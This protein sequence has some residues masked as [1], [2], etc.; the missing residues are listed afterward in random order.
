MQYADIDV[1]VKDVETQEILTDKVIQLTSGLSGSKLVG[2]GTTNAEGNVR[3]PSE[4][5]NYYN[6]AFKG[7]NDYLPAH[8][9]FVMQKDLKVDTTLYLHKKDSTT[10]VVEHYMDN[11]NQDQDLALQIR[12]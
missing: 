11:T 1:Q 5:F 8:Q 4:P 2:S 3:F 10:V 7:D 12:S 6:V 9:S